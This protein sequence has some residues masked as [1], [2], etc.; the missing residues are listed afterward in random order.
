VNP[1]RN[2]RDT[3]L[4]II[5]HAILLIRILFNDLPSEIRFFQIFLFQENISQNNILGFRQNNANYLY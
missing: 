2:G 5:P 3:I 4:I 1:P